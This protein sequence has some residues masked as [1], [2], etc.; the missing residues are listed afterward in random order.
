MQ[1]KVVENQNVK[2]GKMSNKFIL[3]MFFL[4]VVNFAIL[5]VVIIESIKK[6]NLKT[7]SQNSTELV[8]ATSQN[9]TYWVN[10]LFNCLDEIGRASCRERV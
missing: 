5:E 8:D 7:Y 6:N 9:I 2:Y 4:L 3:V 10:S 1:E